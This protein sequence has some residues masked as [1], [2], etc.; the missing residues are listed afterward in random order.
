[1]SHSSR[2]EDLSV[3]MASGVVLAA[4]GLA[5]VWAG[6]AWLTG[7]VALAVGLMLWEAASITAPGRPREAALIGI[8][9][10]GLLAAVIARHDPFALPLLAVPALA[11]AIR[12]GGD[13]AG[14]ALVALAVMV[15]GY[16]IIGFRAAM[17]L[18]FVLWIVAVVAAA[19][20]GGYF[21]GRLLGGPKFWPRLSPKKTW[22]GTL[23][24]WIS[25]AAFGAAF[26]A[27]GAA[28]VWAAPFSVLVAL[29][30]QMGDIGESAFK[31]RAGVKDASRIIPGHGG[32]LDRFDGMAGA[33]VFLLAWGLAFPRPDIGF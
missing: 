30:S 7:F 23:T 2:W 21:G 20:L 1:M 16:A 12:L 17:G 3:R 8:A 6:G 9:G 4:A 5:V 13:R 18:G 25:A 27:A 24:G 11:G 15:A 10:A 32:V 33:L 29:A 22:S 28:P 14:F 31:R 26:A 19:D